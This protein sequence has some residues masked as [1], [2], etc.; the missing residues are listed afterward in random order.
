MATPAPPGQQEPNDVSEGDFYEWMSQQS[1]S[2][3]VVAGKGNVGKST[4]INDLLNLCGDDA[5]EAKNDGLPTTTTV[6]KYKR[7]HPK[8]NSVVYVIDTP[9][10]DSLEADTTDKIVMSNLEKESDGTAH[11]LLY[12]ASLNGRIDGADYRIMKLLTDSFS[13]DIWKRAILVL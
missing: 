4:L 7:I 11:L 8:V 13:K 2:V 3:I 5:A 12:C 9:G 6:T 10:F 1:E